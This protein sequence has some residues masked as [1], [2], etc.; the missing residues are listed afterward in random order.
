MKKKPILEGYKKEG[1]KFT[2]PMKMMPGGFKEVH[3]VDCILPEIVWLQYLV[4]HLGKNKGISVAIE[5]LKICH[6]QQAECAHDPCFL[7]ALKDFGDEDWSKITEK[8]KE[9][10]LLDSVIGSLRPF[11]T[12]YPDNNPLHSLV[13][14]CDEPEEYDFDSAYEAVSI[15]FSRYTK[16][17][18]LTQAIVLA[19]GFSIEKVKISSE[20]QFPEL[21]KIDSDFDSPE[22][23]HASSFVRMFVNSSFTVGEKI[24][25][26]WA[27]YF[28][29]RCGKLTEF[30]SAQHEPEPD[31]SDLHP[32]ES[33]AYRFAN[34][35]DKVR[36]AIWNA[37]PIDYYASEAYEVIGGLLSRQCSLA[38]KLC[39]PNLLDYESGP[40]FLRAL[41]DNYIT[42][43]WLLIDPTDR[44]R[45]FI[46]YGLGQERLQIEHLRSELESMPES[47]TKNE[48]SES[49]EARVA[50]L[51]DQHWEFLQDVDIGAWAGISTRNMAIEADCLDLYRFAYA[52]WSQ[53]AHGTWNHVSRFNTRRTSDPLKKH[54][55]C[56]TK[57]RGQDFWVMMNGCKYLEMMFEEIVGHYDL[58]IEWESLY[59]WV[60]DE[61][62][63]LAE[64]L[65]SHASNK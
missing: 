62:Y 13:G 35:V 17:S 34:R 27:E 29:N 36:D 26:S 9:D 44:S 50:W 2:S 15:L 11:V 18:I 30:K 19:Y 22:A 47:D 51:N 53:A 56:P 39:N 43:A 31:Y 8:L 14:D 40:L 61:S 7:T 41:V 48:L 59:D 6:E 12:I 55:F 21:D 63:K 28:W 38:K 52:P 42:V 58:K 54:I 45:K 33:F 64:A 25:S 32:F 65:K 16:D 49:I 24:D 1:K 57:S 20:V 3:Y 60:H 37:L 10:G 4:D 23:R 46:D 5:F